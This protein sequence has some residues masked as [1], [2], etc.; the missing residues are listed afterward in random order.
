MNR[1]A[2]NRNRS[3][4]STVE[5]LS[6]ET[7]ADMLTLLF[8][9]NLELL[10]A[11]GCVDCTRFGWVGDASDDLTRVFTDLAWR[12]DEQ[13]APLAELRFGSSKATSFSRHGR[14][15]I[16]ARCSPTCSRAVRPATCPRWISFAC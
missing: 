9:Y 15:A 14:S 8:A 13:L 5:L 11:G 12:T 7:N 4:K 2:L 6:G 3:D 16:L 10:V 1:S